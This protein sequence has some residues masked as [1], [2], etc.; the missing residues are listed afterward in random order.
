MPDI[1][2]IKLDSAVYNI[3]D[4]TARN[5]LQTFETNTNQEIANLKIPKN[6]FANKKYLLI[7]DSYAEGYTPD[8]NVTSWQEYFINL[9]GLSNTIRKYQGGAGFVNISN[10]KNFETLLEEVTSDDNI[11]DIVVL[12]GYNDTSYN[13]QQIYNAI[14]SFQLKA[15][16]KFPNANIYIGEVGWSTDSSKIYLLNQTIRRY[17]INAPLCNC[18]YLTN[19]EYALHEYFESF[20]SDGFHPNSHGQ[21]MIALCLIQA[22]LT[23]SADVQ[24]DYTNINITPETDVTIDRL[25]NFGCTL[26]NNIVEVSSQNTDTIFRFATPITKTGRTSVITI[27]TIS[28]GYIIGSSYS[29]CWI[30]VKCVI[31]CQ[32]GFKNAMGLLRILNGKLSIEFGQAND[33]G[34]NYQ[35]Y[36][37]ITQIQISAFHGIFN[38]AFC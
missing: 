25:N 11:T 33:A 26:S 23:G 30:P 8:G 31:G 28:S 38:S 3:K 13:N 16:E 22:L 9:T 4:E 18:G 27:G 12:G 21:Y 29:I 17:K 1:S 24:F 34:D 36:T 15:N 14:K 35:T 19:I 5:N 37:N 2:K 20:S 10:N 7:G 6:F 32:E